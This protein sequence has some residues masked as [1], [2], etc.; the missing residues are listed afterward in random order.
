MAEPLER[1]GVPHRAQR[2]ACCSPAYEAIGRD[3][4][5]SVDFWDLISDDIVIRDRPE[6]PDP[7][8][9][10]GRTGVR[11]SLASSDESFEQFTWSRSI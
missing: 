2:G 1:A 9:Y 11:E 6:A 10:Q 4:I 7:Q 3:D 8:T 5:D